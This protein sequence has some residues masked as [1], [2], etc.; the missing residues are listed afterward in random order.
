MNNNII[1]YDESYERIKKR[2]EEINKN[3][4]YLYV[5]GPKG[6]KGDKG[7]KG[8]SSLSTIDIG[9]VETVPSDMPAE[10]TNVGTDEN[11]ILDFKIPRG[12][13]G[14]DGLPGEKGEQGI[15]GPEGPKGEQGIPGE[16]GEEGPPGPQ[17]DKGISETITID[18][19]Q[20]IESTEEASVIDDFK[21]N[22]HHLTF[23][24]PKG[25]RGPAGAG[26]GA[27]SYNAIISVRY[28]DA[29][30]SRALTIKEKTFLPSSTTIFTVPSTI[31]ININSTGI[32]EI[33]LCGKITGVTQNNGASFYLWNTT[34][35]TIINNLTFSLLEG[36]TSDMTFS[37][38]T[39][40]E[41][42]APATFQVKTNITNSLSTSDISFT[43][44]NLIMKRYNT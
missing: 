5:Q 17:G 9:K 39:I 28:A 13:D 19:T 40:T 44:I 10:V 34:T 15:P 37:G 25:E 20:T 22:T 31:N 42:F 26:A 27:T 18:G 12:F 16:K 3:I 32:Y 1:D 6:E 41:V 21:D 2:I 36:T 11:I 14:I 7:D 43:D 8:E 29:K 24:I 30:D 23:N 33:M 38:T 4:K 35:G